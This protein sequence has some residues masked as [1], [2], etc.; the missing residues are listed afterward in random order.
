MNAHR[1]FDQKSSDRACGPTEQKACSA[2]HN[3]AENNEATAPQI[4]AQTP[5]DR[6][7]TTIKAAPVP[8]RS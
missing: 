7:D 3:A 1:A 8:S 6:N 2:Y 4:A 5:S